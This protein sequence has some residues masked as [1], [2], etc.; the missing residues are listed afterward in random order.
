VADSEKPSLDTTEERFRLMVDSV[1]DYAIFMLDPDGR[2]ATWNAGAEAL[3]GYSAE[4]IIGLHM[5]RFY[6]PETLR[7][8]RPEK[9]LE[10]ARSQGRAEDEGWRV[11][12]DGSRFWADVV[13]TA[14]R[15]S[16]GK[17]VGYAKVTRD[18]TARRAA[19]EALRRSEERLRLMVDAV[20][21]Y[22]IFMLSPEGKVATWNAGAERIKGYRAEEVL[23]QSIETFYPEEE[24]GTGKAARELEA[25]ARDGR[26]EEEGW[27]VRKN[28]ARF[29]A[30]VILSAVRD[31]AGTLLGFT[32]ITRDLTE[33]RKLDQEQ[34]RAAQADE[35]IRLRDEFLSIA[36]H[37]LRTPL[38]SL[39]LQLESVSERAEGLDGKLAARLERARH[40]AGRLSELIE[41]L[42][43]VSRI[44]TGHFELKRERLD[45][46]EICREVVDRLGEV[47]V[48][49]KCPVTFVA[50]GPVVG[51]WDRLRLEQLLVN[52]LGNAFK[53]A[54]GTPVQVTVRKR[55]EQAEVE[56]K[57]QGPGIP[58]SELS[59]VFGRFERASSRFHHGGL[60][61]GLYVNRQIAEAH[62][63]S[64][65]GRN[66]PGV[67]A[68]FLIT[69]PLTP[70]QGASGIMGPEAT[71]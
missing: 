10:R 69:L 34:L 46:V 4:E 33:R 5:S 12:K 61:L 29:W 3:K 6:P 20:K 57:D 51:E 8:G 22:A 55:G 31:S 71:P 70:G 17:L 56:V 23:G 65:Q 60:G 38:T 47:A 49:A 50:E 40:T 53:Y 63:G 14:L 21:D 36:S 41:T 24:R 26:F 52:L 68:A 28:G 32:K 44:S 54:G 37:E 27:R 11:R 2:I 62:G 39:Q 16:Q 7:E 35:A 30:N 18:L 67:G 25:A 13:L 64:I 66:V 19:E 48:S 43:D 1:K 59:R 58:E 42:L 9:L 45:A 15:D